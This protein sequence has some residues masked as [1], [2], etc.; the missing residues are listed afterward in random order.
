LAAAQQR[1]VRALRSPAQVLA[2]IATYRRWPANTLAWL[3]NLSWIP[4]GTEALRCIS[5]NPFRPLPPRTF[6]VHV[7]GLAQS[8]YA[9]FP[10]VSP[11]Y[12][13]LADA[14]EELGEAEAAAHCHQEL[15]ARGCHVVDWITGRK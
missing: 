13:I 9:T 3:R 1:A 11:E 8:I 4:R 10:T 6:P 5:G 2:Y 14:L 12:A 7:I 15:H